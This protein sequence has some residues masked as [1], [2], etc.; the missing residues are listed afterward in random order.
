MYITHRVISVNVTVWQVRAGSPM[1]GAGT[2]QPSDLMPTAAVRATFV[3]ALIDK[4]R[5]PAQNASKFPGISRVSFLHD[6]G[7]L[8]QSDF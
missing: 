6:S 5:G 7:L 4:G 8:C 2:R 1:S 3:D